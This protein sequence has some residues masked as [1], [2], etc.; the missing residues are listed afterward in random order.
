MRVLF[1]HQNF[2]GQFLH[3]VRR[4]AADRDNDIVFIAE[5]NDKHIPGVRRVA[6]QVPKGPNP[7][8]HPDIQDVEQS[9]ARAAAVA[10]TAT[11]VKALGFTP[12]IIIGHHGWGEL[13]N[14]QDVWP[15]APLLGYCEFYYNLQGHDV[16]FDPEFPPDPTSFPRIRARN[17][18]NLLALTNPG[19]GQTPTL[20]QHSTY[21]DWAR[22]RITVLP[23]GVDT[24][25]CKPA[26]A[27]RRAAFRLGD[28]S[29]G[30]GEKLLTYVSR[31]LEPY[32][33]FHTIMRALPR[34]LRERRD[35]RVILVG[36]DEVSYG[37]RLAGATWREHFLG[38][39]GSGIDP[40]RV[41]FPGRLPYAD[42][43][44]VLQRSDAHVYLTYP[45]VASWS[46]REALAAGCVVI[47]SDT[48]PV[49]EFVTDGQNGLLTP[50]LDPAALVDQVLR[51]LEDRGLSRDLRAR[52]RRGAERDLALCDYLARYEG[53]IGSLVRR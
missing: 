53:L 23:E 1:V 13:L 22:A 40:A 3:I 2:P 17:T 35:L 36:G 25:R 37:P 14:L 50:C 30:P 19:H 8:T 51:V 5:P 46:L 21:P 52:A 15:E 9:I 28:V 26:P 29:I 34:L 38:E 43:V 33:G 18:V 12:D 48:P 39:L 7:A 45:F 11:A 32:R 20:W 16:D 31:D 49:R 24:E 41:H 6:Y 44:R 47:G 4:L 10:R 42:Y 27:L